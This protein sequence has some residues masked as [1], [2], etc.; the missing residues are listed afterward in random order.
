[1]KDLQPNID[2]AKI[3]A[4][5]L[6]KDI[7]IRP[8]IERVPG[9]SNPEYGIGRQNILADLKTMSEGSGTFFKSRMKSANKQG[10]RLVVMNIDNYKGAA[11]D[12]ALKIKQGF[13]FGGKQ[14]YTNIEKI[15]II[16]NGKVIQITRNQA[17][18]GMFNDLNKLK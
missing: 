1:L 6:G 16:R 15:I 8:H 14:I 17:N 13:E 2:A 7:Y 5:F 11:A 10:C 12:L 9:H 18:K 3:I 4:D